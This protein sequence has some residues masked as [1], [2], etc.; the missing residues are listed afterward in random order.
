VFF[1]VP[2][3][4]WFAIIT[5]S[6]RGIGKATA[7]LL[8]KRGVNVVICSRSEKE[9]N[10]AVQEIKKEINDSGQGNNNSILGIKCDVS[11]SSQVNSL[12]KR[13]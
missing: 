1:Y 3:P 12:I 9:I 10:S 4:E 7:I 13:Q 8:A 2:Y 6:S 5:G 11:I